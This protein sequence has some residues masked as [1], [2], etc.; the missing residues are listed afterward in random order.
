MNLQFQRYLRTCIVS[1]TQNNKIQRTFY[2][3]L[4]VQ[5]KSM[6]PYSKFRLIL[7]VDHITNN[8]KVKSETLCFKQVATDALSYRGY[9]TNKC[10]VNVG[11]AMI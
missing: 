7:L 8:T 11:A 10:T 5:L 9:E 4:F 1:A 6:S 2:T 3:T